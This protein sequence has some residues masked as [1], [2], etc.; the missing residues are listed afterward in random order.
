MINGTDQ[1]K[2]RASP[3]T[4]CRIKAVPGAHVDD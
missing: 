4:R 3:E 1:P 2:V